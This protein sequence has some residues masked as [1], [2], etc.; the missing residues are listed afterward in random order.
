LE[1][2]LVVVMV[3]LVALVVLLVVEVYRAP[4]LDRGRCCQWFLRNWRD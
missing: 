1:L 2:V 4:V 3:A